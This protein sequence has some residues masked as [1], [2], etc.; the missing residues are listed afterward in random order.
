VNAREPHQSCQPQLRLHK[1][2]GQGYVT[3]HG[4]RR[5]LGK[6]GLRE[7]TERFHRFM[8]EVAAAGR[9]WPQATPDLSVVELQ[10]R[11]LQHAKTYY[12]AS[13][14]ELENYR[15]SLRPLFDLYG[16]VMVQREMEF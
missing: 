2:S 7:T 15:L 10:A 16:T 11:F 6:Y 9:A 8:A 1:G 4:K 13:S 3:V 14:S 12:G 5:Y